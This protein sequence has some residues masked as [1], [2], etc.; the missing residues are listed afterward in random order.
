[1]RAE[2]EALSVETVTLSNGK[3]LIRL[4]G[5]A[6]ADDEGLVT[7]VLDDDEARWLALV[8][9]PTALCCMGNGPA[10]VPSDASARVDQPAIEGQ[11]TIDEALDAAR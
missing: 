4:K 10:E 8:A 7:M 1:M 11:T 5:L 3:P 6:A 9:L 2:R